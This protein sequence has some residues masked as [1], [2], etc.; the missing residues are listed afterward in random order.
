[1]TARYAWAIDTALV[2]GVFLYNLPIVFALAPNPSTFPLP[3]LLVSIGLC[4]PY[5]WR[6]SY[7]LVSYAVI[8]SACL[9]Q[10]I[11]NEGILGANVMVLFTVF[12]IA[13]RYKLPVS[14]LAAMLASACLLVAFAP[15]IIDYGVQF[16]VQSSLI[17]VTIAAWLIGVS[18]RVWRSYIA[19]LKERTLQLE[20]EKEAQARII[21]AEERNRIAREI[22]DV[23]SHSLSVVVLMTEG[24]MTRIRDDPN[25][26][27]EALTTARDTG[28]TAMTEMRRMVGVLRTS[29]ASSLSPQPGVADVDTLIE[30]S[31]ATG[32][33]TSL[34]T[35][36]DPRDLPAGLDL[37][38]FRI[39]QEGLT[40]ARKH[41]GTGLSRVDVCLGYTPNDVLVDVRD[42]G[43]GRR[44]SSSEGGH[45]VVGIR[46]RASLYSGT[47]E[48][49]NL[50]S[51]G[52]ALTVRLMIGEDS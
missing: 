27:T 20:R 46:E 39:V 29:E 5:L 52:F 51:G 1:M 17:L 50:P 10:L 23:V 18:L 49:R 41:G 13:T 24:A 30:A 32:I 48:A 19:S 31:S 12:N 34:T 35:Q 21:A 16:G 26:A 22:H 33:A 38:V 9:L 14:S 37:C 6:R 4:F 3:G 2:M 40:N 7:P 44:A 43:G 47:V 25:G 42:D 36:G 45:G 11:V 28:R 15:A 8:C